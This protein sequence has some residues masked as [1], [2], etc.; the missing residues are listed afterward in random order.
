VYKRIRFVQVDDRPPGAID[1]QYNVLLHLSTCGRI[2]RVTV[3]GFGR[4]YSSP[5]ASCVQDCFQPRSPRQ[6]PNR[7]IVKLIFTPQIR[8]G[9]C[10]CSTYYSAIPNYPVRSN[11]TNYFTADLARFVRQRLSLSYGSANFSNLYR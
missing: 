2:G 10:I 7:P 11:F 5:C 8:S 3:M 1:N 4:S 9:F 6:S